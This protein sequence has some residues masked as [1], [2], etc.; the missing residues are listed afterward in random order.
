MMHWHFGIGQYSHRSDLSTFNVL[1]WFHPVAV[2]VLVLIEDDQLWALGPHF[3]PSFPPSCLKKQEISD[4]QHTLSC[5]YCLHFWPG[6]LFWP[7]GPSGTHPGYTCLTPWPGIPGPRHRWIAYL[8][9]WKHGCILS[10]RLPALH[11]HPATGVL[12]ITCELWRLMRNANHFQQLSQNRFQL[13]L[14][15]R[16]KTQICLCAPH[17]QCVARL[18]HTEPHGWKS[19]ADVQERHARHQPMQGMAIQYMIEQNNI[20]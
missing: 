16:K 19:S 17:F 18:T 4:P 12:D 10:Q 1:S 2:K 5:P 20:R 9:P 11:W 7:P 8:A 14:F 13:V 6:F 15:C 3:L